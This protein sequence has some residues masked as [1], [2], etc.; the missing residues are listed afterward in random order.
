MK[1]K[2][3]LNLVLRFKLVGDPNGRICAASRI[4]LDGK[5][6]LTLYGGDGHVAYRIRLAELQSFS[7]RPIHYASRA[8]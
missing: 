5:G 2:E 4:K 8:A 3:K 7:I 6:S 1:E